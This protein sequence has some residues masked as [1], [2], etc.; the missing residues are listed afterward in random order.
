MGRGGGAVV[1]RKIEEKKDLQIQ[2]VTDWMRKSNYK[3]WP[4][5][6]TSSLWI[7]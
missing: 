1:K 3:G 2:G 4:E 6:Y 7:H 5:E